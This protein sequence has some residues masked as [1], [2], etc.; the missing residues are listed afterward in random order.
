MK[1]NRN[2]ILAIRT[3]NRWYRNCK[4]VRKRN[5]KICQV[6]PFRKEIETTEGLFL[7]VLRVIEKYKEK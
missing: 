2:L 6:C 3:N 7:K 1:F 5:G 4:N